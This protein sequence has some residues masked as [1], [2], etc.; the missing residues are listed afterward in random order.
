MPH[1]RPFVLDVPGG[2]V[3]LD[4]FVLQQH[5]GALLDSAL[6]ETGLTASQY[7]VYSVLARGAQ[8]P[9]QLRDVLGV[10]AATMSG[11]LSAMERA[12]HATKARHGQDGRSW[13]FSLTPSGRELADDGRAVMRR[14]MRVVNRRL[15]SAGDVAA[16]R[17]TLGEIDAALLHARQRF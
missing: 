14:V 17:A 4:L 2:N 11:Y 16:A 13:V 15:G 5:V 1:E 10:R 7:A 6:A 3:A 9:G 8:T 12:G